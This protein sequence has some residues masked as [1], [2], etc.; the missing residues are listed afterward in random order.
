MGVLR[1]TVAA[2][3][4]RNVLKYESGIL[5]SQVHPGP[6]TLLRRRVQDEFLATSIVEYKVTKS[7]TQVR[8]RRTASPADKSRR[9][10]TIGEIC[11]NSG[12]VHDDR[13]TRSQDA[14]NF[15]DTLCVS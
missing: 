8:A 6:T 4:V 1:D 2:E 15:V 11:Q 7:S 13:D 12:E 14:V 9:E 5:W 3:N 10:G